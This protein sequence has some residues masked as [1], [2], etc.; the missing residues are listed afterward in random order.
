MEERTAA[1]VEAQCLRV[2][3]EQAEE[4]LRYPEG[5]KSPT[6]SHSPEYPPADPPE[7]SAP[8]ATAQGSLRH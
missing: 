8:W 7:A 4:E 2:C 6:R 3:L 5:H 1:E